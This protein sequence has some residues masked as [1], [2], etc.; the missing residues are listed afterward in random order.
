MGFLPQV[1]GAIGGIFLAPET[2][3][4]VIE[5]AMENQ[6][7]VATGSGAIAIGFAW[8][9]RKIIKSK[10]KRQKLKNSVSKFLPFFKRALEVI[11]NWANSETK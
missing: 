1:I 11:E 6:E 4:Q 8:I 9:I 3:K 5:V 7:M 2:T 10:T